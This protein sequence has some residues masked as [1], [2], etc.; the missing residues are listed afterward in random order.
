MS[1]SL[2]RCCYPS[3]QIIQLSSIIPYAWTTLCYDSAPF[4]GYI[5]F[6]LKINV[7]G[8]QICCSHY[9]T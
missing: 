8:V 5:P 6:L 2:E 7:S 3:R 9:S 4:R 1:R